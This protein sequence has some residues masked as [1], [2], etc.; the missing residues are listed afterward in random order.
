MRTE[1]GRSSSGIAALQEA[2]HAGPGVGCEG[3]EGAEVA[4]VGEATWELEV[5]EDPGDPLG[6]GEGGGAQGGKL[7]GLGSDRCLELVVGDDAV[8]EPDG[9]GLIGLDASSGQGQLEADPEA[10]QPE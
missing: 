6:H 7:V 10:S 8:D 1:T 9:D 4:G 3:A 2:G 5:G